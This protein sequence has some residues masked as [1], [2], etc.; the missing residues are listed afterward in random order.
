MEV[1][2]E[3]LGDWLPFSRSIIYIVNAAVLLIFIVL[4]FANILASL[5][6]ALGNVLII[7]RGYTRVINIEDNLIYFNNIEVVMRLALWSR[8]YAYCF[9]LTL[10]IKL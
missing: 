2:S 1:I 3:L 5:L 10:I 6:Y 9:H 8:F 7:L 4:D